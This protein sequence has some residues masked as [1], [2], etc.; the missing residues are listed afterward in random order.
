MVPNFSSRVDLWPERFG[1]GCWH[2]G[3]ASI[4]AIDA[5]DGYA[6]RLARGYE[7]HQARD[8]RRAAA[9]ILGA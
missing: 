7:T 1:A 3:F 9:L 5:K 6:E 8:A 2:A 4:E